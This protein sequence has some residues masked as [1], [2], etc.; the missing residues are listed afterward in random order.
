MAKKSNDQKNADSG[1]VLNLKEAFHVGMAVACAERQ[2]DPDEF[3]KVA[4]AGLALL[5]AAMGVPAYMLYR[6][7]QN[8]G[9]KLGRYSADFWHSDP[10]TAKDVKVEELVQLYN[11]LADEQKLRAI[12]AERNRRKKPTGFSAI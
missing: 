1:D 10:F 2:L 9:R 8:I 4:S 5:A 7:G 12:Q 6:M 11:E 3:T